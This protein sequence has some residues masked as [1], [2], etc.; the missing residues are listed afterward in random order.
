[1]WAASAARVAGDKERKILLLRRAVTHA[2]ASA[3]V[4]TLTHVLAAV[5]FRGLLDG[6]FGVAAE[7]TE[8]LTLA[9]EAR[10][11]NAASIHLA[12][13]AWLAA[14]MGEDHACRAHAAEVDEEAPATANGLAGTIA[15]WAVA[16][17]HLGRGRPVRRSPAWRP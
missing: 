8:G 12:I 11:S 14:V 9:R 15:G 10:L 16:L 13:L 1:V 7:A 17:L 3:A 2:R 5:A 6:R 4:D